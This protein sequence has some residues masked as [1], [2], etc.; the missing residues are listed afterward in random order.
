VHL[1]DRVSFERDADLPPDQDGVPNLR[2]RHDQANL[3]RYDDAFP[4]GLPAIDS[5]QSWEKL[6]IAIT[7]NDPTILQSGAP[8]YLNMWVDGNHN[9][10]WT[11]TNQCAGSTAPEWV[12]QN[13]GVSTSGL[14]TGINIVTVT[15]L[16]VYR[17]TSSNGL[18][19]AW[20]RITLSDS[21]VPIPEAPAIPDGSGPADGWALGETEDH[22]LPGGPAISIDK[23]ADKEVAAAGDEIEFTVTLSNASAEPARVT[24]Y[25]LIPPGTE[26]IPE[27]YASTVQAIEQGFDVGARPDFGVTRHWIVWRGDVP[28]ERERGDQLQGAGRPLRARRLPRD[29]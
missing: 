11:D 19:P 21:P 23:V 28:G 16:P 24:M 3:D 5:C 17:E 25:D 8:L 20:L 10:T 13:H 22:Y 18:L 6:P 26:Y 12:L 15:T 2:P 27:T 14:V 4:D 7:V 1:G 9:G 29:Q